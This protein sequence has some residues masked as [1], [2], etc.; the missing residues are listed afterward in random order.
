[1]T[2][3]VATDGHVATCTLD[4]PERLN[5]IDIDTYDGI[6]AFAERLEGDDDLRVGIITGAGERAF[7]AGADLKKLLAQ[8]Q[9][10]GQGKVPPFITAFQQQAPAHFTRRFLDDGPEHAVK[11]SAALVGQARQFGG[12]A[13][14]VERGAYRVRKPPVFAAVHDRNLSWRFTGRLIRSPKFSP[15]RNR[16][17][18]RS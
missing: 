12:A 15:N 17:A 3:V 1:M 6:V 16:P 2:V 14:Q 8:I 7:S 10:R 11:L 4:R 9:E 18:M 5:A 13:L